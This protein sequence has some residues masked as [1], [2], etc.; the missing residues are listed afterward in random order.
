VEPETRYTFDE[1]KKV[2]VAQE[3]EAKEHGDF[4]IYLGEKGIV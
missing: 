2:F 3:K 1:R 4:A